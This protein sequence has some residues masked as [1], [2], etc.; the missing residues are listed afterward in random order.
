MSDLTPAG[1]E[2]L[3]TREDGAFLFAR[4]GRPLV[5]VVWGASADQRAA[6]FG[7]FGALAD[8]AGV[9]TSGHDPELGANVLVF[10]LRDWAELLR[11]PNLDGLA[12]DLAGLVARLDAEEANQ[13]RI[14]RFDE[15]GAIRLAMVFVRLDTQMSAVPFA[16]V[17]LLQAVQTVLLWSDTAFRDRAPLVRRDGAA[18][19]R[20][21]LA[22][23]IRAAYDPA[24]PALARDA[25]LAYRLAAR[26]GA[27]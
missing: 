25:A 10:V 4:W 18:M 23:L 9:G 17:A 20:P 16:D 24:L 3:F 2:R 7:A 15:A 19:L 26:M 6:I 21:D 5:P 14:F 13:Y 11:I 1:V 22:A 27:A 8:L 12:S